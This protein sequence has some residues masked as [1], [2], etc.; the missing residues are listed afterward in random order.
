NA[1]RIGAGGLGQ[2]LT[3]L[4]LAVVGDPDPVDRTEHDG[5]PVSDHDD[6]P[7]AQRMYDAFVLVIRERTPNRRGGVDRE[8]AHLQWLGG[9]CR[10]YCRGK[11][12]GDRSEMAKHI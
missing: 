2:R 8:N 10:P 5:P 1:I 7:A 11:K 12:K 6:A 4:D 3:E 9:S